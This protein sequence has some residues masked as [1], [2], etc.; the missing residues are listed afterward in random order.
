MTLVCVVWRPML[1]Y[2]L[3]VDAAILAVLVFDALRVA[4]PRIEVR[5]QAARIWSVGRAEKVLISI[6][7]E[8]GAWEVHQ[9]LPAGATAHGLPLRLKS[10]EEK[11]FRVT[12]DRRGRYQLGAHHIRRSSPWRLW[13]RQIDIPAGDD[14]Q[15]WPDL[16]A[17][18]E[19]D[20][21]A[22][23]NL[24]GL[25]TRT[26]RRPGMD[27][28]F[29]RLR[30]WQRGDE[31][32][33]V[34]W[35]ASARGRGPVVR[36]LRAATDQ[37]IVFLLDC[38]RTMTAEHDGRP[39]LDWALDAMLMVGNVALRQGDRVGMVAVNQRICA[40]APPTGGARGRTQL[41]TTSCELTAT[42]EEPDWREAFGFL[43]HHIRQRALIVLFSN[44]VDDVTADALAD[45][46]KGNARHLVVWVCVRDGAVE[47]MLNA[48]SAPP[49][50]AWERGV[51]ADIA[52]WRRGVLDR[53]E[54]NGVLVVD[55]APNEFT[56][57]LLN[58]YLDVKA[59]NLL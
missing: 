26:T 43:R 6:T 58:R 7:G 36:Q 2:A 53:F 25:L 55:A 41:L 23:R 15:V 33:L 19:Y 34:D 46:M 37:R 1:A 20:L 40:W 22:R 21:L 51:A 59:R 12:L 8:R 42:L 56:P 30:P 44:L 52:N 18:A 17:I 29:D 3:Y 5:R 54:Q 57:A 28:E 38:G 45:L 27:A 16:A 13:L 35:K 10:G 32:R 31:Y 39:A 14:F 50:S 47:S 4:A 48:P 9:T 11:N 49:R 24:Q